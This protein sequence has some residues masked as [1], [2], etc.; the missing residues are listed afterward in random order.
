MIRFLQEMGVK[1]HDVIREK[2]DRIEVFIPF[3]SARKR[4][5]TALRHPN[6]PDTV[7]VFVKGAS[8][9][10]IELCDKYFDANGR[11]Q[12]LTNHKKQ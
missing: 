8:E 9:M 6:K 5:C 2:D 1:A 4:A 7:R 3:N 11:E 12:E 10:V